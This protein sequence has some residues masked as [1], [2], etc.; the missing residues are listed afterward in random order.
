MGKLMVE[1]IDRIVTD[2]AEYAIIFLQRVVKIPSVTGNE[3]EVGNF[4][5]QWM[6][7]NL[8]LPVNVYEKTKDRPN[9][10]VQWAGSP[11]GETFLFNGHYDVFPEVPDNPGKYG[12]WSGKIVDGNLYG[13]GS[14]D[15]KGGLCASI[16]ATYLLK[17]AGFIPNGNLI[18]TC[19]ADEEKG[20]ENGITYML[21]NNYIKADYGICVEPS[22][23]K[24]LV[25]GGGGLWGEISIYCSGGHGSIPQENPDAIILISNLIKKISKLDHRIQK[26]RYYTPFG[27]G[28]TLTVT[29]V[30]GGEAENMHASKSKI[31]FDRRLV[32]TETIE[33]AE[34]EIIEIIEDVVKENPT[35]SYQYKR[36][37]CSP[38]YRVDKEHKL[39][40][41]CLKAYKE[42]SGKETETFERAGGSDAHQ[43]ADRLGICIPNF[44]PGDELTETTMPDEKIPLKDYLMFIKIY[45]RIVSELLS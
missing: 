2:N 42:I 35:A 30:A 39:V 45:M 36:K 37:H 4:L 5:K 32:P 19:D 9:L 12:P 3:K 24:I 22:H 33:Q 41:E 25:V 44:G 11:N 28:P 43:I 14:V 40:H 26:D 31:V 10:L 16:M 6:E 34:N 23:D 21:D 8:Q 15:M 7:T 27:V 38:V 18:L 1:D 17:K 13:R 20:G 29:E